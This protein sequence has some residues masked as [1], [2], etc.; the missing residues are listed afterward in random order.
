MAAGAKE[1]RSTRPRGPCEKA[2]EAGGG[3]RGNLTVEPSGFE[4][5]PA[6]VGHQPKPRI[7]RYGAG[8]ATQP[9]PFSRT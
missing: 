7:R 4:S 3:G 9:E 2:V 5:R 6:K 8:S 1:R